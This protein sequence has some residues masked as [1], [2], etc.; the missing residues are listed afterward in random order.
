MP[1]DEGYLLDNRH[2]EAGGR[3]A[4]MSVLF[5]PVTFRQLAAVGVG[6]GWRCWAVGAGG[7]DVPAWLADRVGPAGTVL[8]TDIDT[9]WLPAD[10]PFQVRRHD[11]AADEPPAGPFDVVHARLV[12]VHVPRREAA[13][14]AMVRALRPGGWLVVEDADPTLQPLACP[15]KHGPA[16]QL[17]NRLRRGFRELLARRSADP[18]FGRTLPR[19]LRAAGLVDVRAEGF[20]PVA[21]AECTALEA[22]TVRQ[23]RPRLVEAGLATDAEIDEHLRNVATGELDLTTAPLISARARK[24]DR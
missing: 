16:E 10:A 19:L 24:P 7:P 14:A 17:A 3:F 2:R 13:L 9:S 15:D 20:F 21:S 1:S 11:V 8:A 23:I 6:P 18:A 12:L 22:A 4:A 5:D